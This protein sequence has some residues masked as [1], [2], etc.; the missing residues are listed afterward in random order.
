MTVDNFLETLNLIDGVTTINLKRKILS[1]FGKNKQFRHCI[2]EIVHNLS[3]RKNELKNSSKLR[4][5]NRHLEK[6]MS[7]EIPRKVRSAEIGNLGPFIKLILPV[8]T[9]IIRSKRGRK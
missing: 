5:Y 7:K 8:L 2:R 3:K 1:E 6:I 9:Q 4:K